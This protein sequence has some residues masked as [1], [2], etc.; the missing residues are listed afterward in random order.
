MQQHIPIGYRM[1]DGKI[2]VD[3]ERA[4]VVRRIFAD[5]LSGTPTYIIAKGLIQ[6]GV[7]NL[8]GEASWNH[9]A[10]GKILNNAKY[11]GEDCYPQLIEKEVFEQVQAQRKERCHNLGRTKNLNSKKN[12]GVFSGRLRC[13]ECGEVF[14]RYA[15]RR[16]ESTLSNWKCKNYL[17][18]GL[19]YCNCGHI[20][21]DQIMEAFVTAANKIIANQRIMRRR[22]K[23][24]HHYSSPEYRRLDQRIREME[25]EGQFTS[26]ELAGLIFQRAAAAYQMAV[27]Q[28]YEYY[29]ERLQKAFTG[30]ERMDEFDEDLFLETVKQM[31]I[32]ADGRLKT[33]FINGLTIEGTYEIRTG[34]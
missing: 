20:Y 12:Q 31:I 23:D 25:D 32:Y 14:H 2:C 33:E 11:L 24:D 19:V 7:L 17:H 8:R 22:L 5:Y 27:V 1:Q 3:E 34:R 18:K 13:G 26:L 28:D 4:E 29:T 10:I 9:G 30:R 15:L 21:D 6:K 16:K